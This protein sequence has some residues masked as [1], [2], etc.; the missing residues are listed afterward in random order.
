[1]DAR[2]V[3]EFGDLGHGQVL[4]VAMPEDL[5]LQR[6]QSPACPFPE[7]GTSVSAGS[8]SVGGMVRVVQGVVQFD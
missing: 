8:D 1:M 2:Q 7:V 4:M 5:E 6:R 3:E